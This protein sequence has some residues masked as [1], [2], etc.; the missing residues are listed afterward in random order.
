[1]NL[2]KRHG[3]KLHT[4]LALYVVWKLYKKLQNVTKY[5]YIVIQIEDELVIKIWEIINVDINRYPLNN[6]YH[7]VVN[8]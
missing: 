1:M 2:C 4:T 7:F 8:L 6:F 5:V 3:K